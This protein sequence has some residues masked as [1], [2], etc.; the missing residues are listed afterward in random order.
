MYLIAHVADD[1]GQAVVTGALEAAD[2]LGS[3]PQ[4]LPPQ[5]LLFCSTQTGK[6]SMVRQIE[7]ELHIDADPTTL[8]DL[9][10]FVPQLLWVEGGGVE[11]GPECAE[12]VRSLAEYF[13][14]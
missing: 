9:R 12:H 7:P 3:S 14:G 5:R 8:E 11:E 1:I 6:Q 4:H 2:L 10:R 13:G